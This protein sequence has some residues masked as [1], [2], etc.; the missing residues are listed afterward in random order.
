M[1][2]FQMW[3]ATTDWDFLPPVAFF[4]FVS[5]FMSWAF[6]RPPLPQW[7]LGALSW[8]RWNRDWKY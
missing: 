3:V 4:L 5:P 2:R 6:G 1:T 7:P 8:W